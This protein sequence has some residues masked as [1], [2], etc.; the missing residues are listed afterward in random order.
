M[1]IKQAEALTPGFERVLE[2][3]DQF[4]MVPIQAEDVRN[5]VL[6]D[7]RPIYELRRGL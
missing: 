2:S 4:G 3:P 7:G 1:R 6:P 5:G